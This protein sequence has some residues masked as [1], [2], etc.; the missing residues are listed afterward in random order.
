MICQ[1]SKKWEFF[2][3]IEDLKKS[4]KHGL[5]SEIRIAPDM[6]LFQKWWKF[7]KCA[8]HE[9]NPSQLQMFK[10]IAF[11]A[12]LVYFGWRMGCATFFSKSLL[13][14]FSPRPEPHLG[15]NRLSEAKPHSL[16][17][18]LLGSSLIVPIIGLVCLLH[19]SHFVR[20]RSPDV[21]PRW[22]RHPLLTSFTRISS[23]SSFSSLELF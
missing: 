17:Q 2:M 13:I 1:L 19:S 11:T 14:P 9:K 16:P 21:L 15:Q 12:G 20:L 6:Q 10:K 23:I 5:A 4:E 18:Q 8:D 7:E 22:V 3:K